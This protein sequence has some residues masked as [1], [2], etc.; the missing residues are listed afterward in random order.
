M[1]STL[2]QAAYVC[3]QANCELTSVQATTRE[4]T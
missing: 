3:E 1:V 4:L 2:F